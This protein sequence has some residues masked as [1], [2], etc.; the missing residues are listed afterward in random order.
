MLEFLPPLATLVHS[1]THLRHTLHDAHDEMTTSSTFEAAIETVEALRLKLPP[2]L[3]NPRVAIVCGS[4][5]GGLKDVVNDVGEEG[6]EGGRCEWAYKD[7]VGFPVST[8][9]LVTL[10]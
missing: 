1:I 7:V 8:G 9:E 5:L 2:P 6:K 10:L 4:G 3:A